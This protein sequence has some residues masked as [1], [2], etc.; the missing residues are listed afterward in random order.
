MKFKLTSDEIGGNDGRNRRGNRATRVPQILDTA[1]R[2][3]ATEGDAGFTQRRVATEAGLR[4]SG[5]QHY[6]ASRDSLIEAMIEEMASR[7]LERYRALAVDRRR[8]PEQRLDAI[9]DETFADF[10]ASGSIVG[11]FAFECWSVAE[12]KVS[13][14]HIMTKVSRSFAELFAALIS[15]NDS[16]L[17]PH[18]CRIRGALMFSHWQGL[19]VVLRTAEDVSGDS[20]AFRTATKALWRALS[21]AS[22]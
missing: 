4:L 1:I 9:L 8:S 20:V 21:S 3:F 13:V 22:T 2:V 5:L 19:I 18:E 10:T 15:E 12:R 17:S 7:Y 16:R 6:F 11:S 14:R